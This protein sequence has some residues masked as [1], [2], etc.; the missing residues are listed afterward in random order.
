[1]AGVVFMWS[2]LHLVPRTNT[3]RALFGCLAASGVCGQIMAGQEAG[4]VEAKDRAVAGDSV[5]KARSSDSRTWANASRASLGSPASF[6]S[7]P[8]SPTPF[9]FPGLGFASVAWGD[10]D[11]DGLMDLLLAG[12]PQNFPLQPLHCEVW[13]NTG[14]GFTNILVNLPGVYAC[15]TAW[16]DFDN[17]E[18]LDILI[19]GVDGR[20]SF[21]CEVWLNTAEGFEKRSELRV[22][23]PGFSIGAIGRVDTGDFDN[24]GLVDIAI[25]ARY[26][27]FGFLQVWRNTG[28]GFT[29]FNYNLPDRS[30]GS[31]AAGDV[32]SDGWL[33]LAAQ[34]IDQGDGVLH[35]M[36]VWTNSSF[37]LEPLAVVTSI[38]NGPTTIVDYD[39]DGREDLAFSG[40]A[41]LPTDLNPSSQIWLNDQNAFTNSGLILPSFASGSFAWADYDSDGRLDL[42]ATS[43]R[44]DAINDYHGSVL[45][46]D[47]SGTTSVWSAQIGEG[48][49]AAAWAD[50]DNDGRIDFVHSGNNWAAATIPT[51]LWRNIFPKTNSPPSA[52]FGLSVT[53]ANGLARLAWQ[54][55]NDEETPGA[56]LTYNVRVGTTPGGGDV[57][58]PM[59]GLDGARR[60]PALGNARYRQFLLF[61]FNP[62]QTYYWSVQAVDG[63]LRGGPF[64]Q[65]ASF[66]PGSPPQIVEARLFPTGD[67]YVRF[68]GNTGASYRIEAANGISAL[69]AETS[70]INIGAATEQPDGYFD[71]VDVSNATSASR[72]YRVIQE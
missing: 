38:W 23:R 62:G 56:S 1:M 17:D 50:F 41:A 10:Y 39:S 3:L 52:P 12:T 27:E 69:P 68:S 70:W 48:E 9:T 63:G 51:T 5:A 49:H 14:A 54:A 4:T 7:S 30:V 36:Q 11:N 16:A 21:L 59:A 42:L 44:A 33:D 37:G 47:A 6:I 20:Y 31:L 61:R 13:R 60:I 45:R 67:F 65:E 55:A 19:S 29:N 18:R 25:V 8:F 26:N 34:G 66:H 24:D 2:W 64:A 28:N 32:N 53:T 72:F 57:I 15:S 35:L 43:V 40:S 71:Y 58:S 46:F 22:T